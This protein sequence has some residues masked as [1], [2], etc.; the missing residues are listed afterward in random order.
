[1]MML[2]VVPFILDIGRRWYNHK[3]HH[4]TAL[5]EVLLL[6]VHLLMFM[7]G[8][9]LMTILIYRLVSHHRNDEPTSGIMN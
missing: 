7:L 8:P 6:L 2:R 3:K 9:Q 1:M 5:F 4:S